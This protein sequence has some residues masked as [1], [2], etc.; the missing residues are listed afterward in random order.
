MCFWFSQLKLQLHH[1]TGTENETSMIIL[2]GDSHIH[3]WPC[4]S[5][6][7]CYTTKRQA[8]IEP[9]FHTGFALSACRRPTGRWCVT[10]CSSY[11]R[12]DGSSATCLVT[13]TAGAPPHRFIH[14]RAWWP[15]MQVRLYGEVSRPWPITQWIHKKDKNQFL[16]TSS[17]LMWNFLCQPV[18]CLGTDHVRWV[19]AHTVNAHDSSVRVTLFY[20]FSR[21]C[22]YRSG[23]L[24]CIREYMLGMVIDAHFMIRRNFNSQTSVLYISGAGH[25]S[26]SQGK[27]IFL[28]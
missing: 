18:V 8:K 9:W 17:I 12:N 7:C 15:K 5:E 14:T 24:L 26:F 6:D 16:I 11:S 28:K 13:E 19:K 22:K 23:K 21:M 27:K 10:G 3:T 1:Q 25:V 20:I 4:S 2:K